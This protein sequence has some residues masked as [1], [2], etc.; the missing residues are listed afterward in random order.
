MGSIPF[1]F[2]LLLL[3]V[4]SFHELVLF[5]CGAK[6]GTVLANVIIWCEVLTV[7]IQNDEAME[8]GVENRMPE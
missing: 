1:V 8:T 3:F 5:G 7:E 2:L 6:L 4:L